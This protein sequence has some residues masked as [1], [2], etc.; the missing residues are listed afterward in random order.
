MQREGKRK[1]RWRMFSSGR[2][3]LKF[4]YWWDFLL[5]VLSED[6][7]VSIFHPNHVYHACLPR[8]IAPRT[9]LRNVCVMLGHI[10]F[11]YMIYQCYIRY[12]S[13]LS[14]KREKLKLCHE[15][16]SGKKGGL[17]TAVHEL[18][19][20]FGFF[21]LQ[22]PCETILRFY[23]YDG[24]YQLAPTLRSKTMWQKRSQHYEE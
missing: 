15:N 8:L 17:E 24:A 14:Q 1:Q 18:K 7:P 4:S 2:F 9:A 3:M 22:R 12:E 20:Y 11:N 6:F 21:E 19:Y 16:I 10:Q 5:F 13:Q 23:A